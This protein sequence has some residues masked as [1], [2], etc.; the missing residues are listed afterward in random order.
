MNVVEDIQHHIRQASE[1]A[2]HSRFALALHHHELAQKAVDHTLRVLGVEAQHAR[3]RKRA[4][5]CQETL[6]DVEV[7][8]V[9]LRQA[10][11][12][13]ATDAAANTALA[14]NVVGRA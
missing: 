11:E 10:I 6:R 13:A 3:T 1:H 4:A 5:H 8:L 2:R 12:E 14:S 9:E 7:S